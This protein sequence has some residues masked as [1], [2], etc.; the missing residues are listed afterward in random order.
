MNGSRR[1]S[2]LPR[3]LAL[4]LASGLLL[5]QS[6]ANA[7]PTSTGFA[8]D[9]YQPA[10]AGSDW[11]QAES[12]DL[13][14]KLRPGLGLVGNYSYQ[15]LVV[16]DSAGEEVD[17]VVRYQFFYHLGAHLVLYERL[18]LA[19]SLPLVLYSVGGQG[20]LSEVAGIQNVALSS[21]SGSGVGDARFSADLRI[22][23]EY[24]GPFTLALGTR[25]FAAIGQET[26]FT[27][28]GLARV[29]GRL[30]AAGQL[31][32]FTYATEMGLL[33][34]AERDDFVGQPF[35]TD[36]TFGAAAGLSLMDGS[37]HLGPELMGSTVVSDSGTGFLEGT[38]T[39][40]ELDFGAKFLLAGAIRL[41]AAIGTGLTSGLGTP[42]LRLLASLEWLLPLPRPPAAEVL[43]APSRDLDGDGVLDEADSCV[44]V[45]GPARSLEPARNGC[46]DPVDSDGDRISDAL[47][48][49]PNEPG[50]TSADPA[51]HGCVPPLDTDGDGIAD[52]VDAC[53]SVKGILQAQAGISGCPVDSD[54]DGVADALDSCPSLA[55]E[56]T[57]AA[58]L[59]GCPKARLEQDW[60]VLN[61]PV[62]FSPTGTA[63][64]TQSEGVLT[65][66]VELLVQHS[67]IELLNVEGHTDSSGSARGNLKL[68]RERAG[69][70]VAWLVRHGISARRL[71]SE[72]FGAS[73][74][75]DTNDTPQGRSNNR[76]LELRIVRRSSGN[77]PAPGR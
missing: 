54:R 74:P 68:S 25:V 36:L 3:G 2:S 63:I 28:D 69:S 14:G 24:G 65:A 59:R 45:P 64:L 15:P 5:V 10:A 34:H 27:S 58:M 57:P 73:V 41:G 49:C 61:E 51:L 23:G 35:G 21:Y 77:E 1:P 37:I 9:R 39:P 66:V 31:G 8:L 19:A 60:I 70:V 50:P 44:D 6:L 12:L 30:M 32:K 42:K 72:G 20:L 26:K 18:R 62:R 75:V 43:L 40:I 13:R 16:L 67:E 52:P 76:R 33:W 22:V 38:S 55:G 71:T 29:S 46:P 7:A 4:V 17:A 11:F 48:A 56:D 47:D 53:P